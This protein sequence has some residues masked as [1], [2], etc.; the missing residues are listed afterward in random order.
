MAATVVG[1]GC[2]CKVGPGQQACCACLTGTTLRR[3]WQITGPVTVNNNNCNRCDEFSFPA[4][5]RRLF[6]GGDA[7]PT[8]CS[9]FDWYP[10]VPRCAVLFP[11][12]AEECQ[13]HFTYLLQYSTGVY[14]LR[15]NTGDPNFPPDIIPPTWTIE[16]D[17]FNCSGANVLT[18]VPGTGPACVNWPATMTIT[19]SPDTI[20]VCRCAPAFDGPIATRWR[21]TFQGIGNGICNCTLVNTEHVLERNVTGPLGPCPQSDGSILCCYGKVL[22]L[23]E[24][25]VILL[26]FSINPFTTGSGTVELRLIHNFSDSDIIYW[27]PLTA[28]VPLGVNRLQNLATSCNRS[29]G[30]VC[31]DV[32]WPPFVDLVPA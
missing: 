25:C 19:P 8:F 14:S 10:T 12:P 3:Y 23:S 26:S 17:A 13:A 24:S 22:T 29:R 31:D 11:P 9:W 21:V 6:W 16:Q 7:A 20:S 1:G 30:S 4:P 2:C 27:M 15:A 28:F 5:G 32:T 18:R